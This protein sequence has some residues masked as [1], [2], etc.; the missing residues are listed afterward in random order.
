[1]WL[2]VAV[3]D[4]RW[5]FRSCCSP[6]VDDGEGNVARSGETHRGSPVG[7]SHRIDEQRANLPSQNS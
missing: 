3:G 6:P 4:H 1:L 5:L 7:C 2:L